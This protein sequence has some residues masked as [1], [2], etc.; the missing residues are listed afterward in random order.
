MT[1]SP[2]AQ[3]TDVFFDSMRQVGDPPADS[4]V[5]VLLRNREVDAV[6]LLLRTLTENDQPAPSVLPDVVREFLE[7]AEALPAWA[8]PGKLA[9]GRAVFERHRDAILVV[10]LCGSLPLGYASKKGVQALQRVEKLYSNPLRRCADAALG[11][12]GLFG[13]SAVNG[14]RQQRLIHAA[15]RAL[16]L[17][18]GKWDKDWDQPLNQ[19]DMAGSVVALSH[20]LTSGLRKLGADLSASDAEALE[21]TIHA[22]APALGVQGDLIPRSAEDAAILASHYERRQF[23]ACSEGREMTKELAEALDYLVPGDRFDG[24][25][26]ELMRY[27]LGEENAEA[28]GLGPKLWKKW[29]SAPSRW[30]GGGGGEGPKDAGYYGALAGDFA[31]ALRIGL[32]HVDRGGD[33]APFPG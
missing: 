1:P 11:A 13:P 4:A 17:H 9:A 3:W 30:L 33:L 5:A 22:A 12:V 10:A 21:H 23:A 2:T 19:E 18:G 15:A 6:H 20:G 31:K 29:I 16:L 26:A 24:T 25:A 14:A 7:R 28:V 32:A 27:L 8:D